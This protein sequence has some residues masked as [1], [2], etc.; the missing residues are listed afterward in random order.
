MDL[1]LFG[2]DLPPE[3]IAQSPSR[4]RDLSRLLVLDRQSGAIAHTQFKEIT[5][6]IKSGDALV[7]N[8]TKVFKARL[9]GQRSSG[10]KIEVFLVRPAHQSGFVPE[11]PE[12]MSVFWEAMVSPSRRI[13]SGE[14]IHFD[15]SHFVTIEQQIADGRWIVFFDSL[16]EQNRIIADFGHIPL[17]HY[18]DR[19]D[20]EQ[21]IKRYQTV[22]A[23]KSKIGAVAAP[24]AGFH[25]T[26]AL[27]R[28][29]QQMGVS[30]VEVTLHVG[31]GTFKPIK[32]DDIREH[33]VDPEYAEIS[34]EVASVIN[35]TRN[36]GGK[37]IAVGTTS[38]RTL[39]SSPTINGEIEPFSKM[40]NLFIQPGH[41]FTYV[42]SMVT[43]FHLP[44]SSLL[45][46]VASFAGR[47]KI[48]E[49]YEQAIAQDYRFYSYGDAM[50][51][52]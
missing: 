27:L 12:P 9:W 17:P 30:V 21:D 18:I 25:F 8:N 16:S 43:N 51:I 24:T 44:K 49:A 40:V 34:S 11:R 23:D 37:I 29:I 38:V 6:Y 32:C 14:R 19:Q 42:D 46:L 45:V 10:G 28:Q 13:K 7:L 31:P 1:S 22:Y 20:E 3:L 15:K 26:K 35:R 41:T 2:F 39:E 5:R 47:E 50:L 48:L 33:K 52:L 4:R 36:Q